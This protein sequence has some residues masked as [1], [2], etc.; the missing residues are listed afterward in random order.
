MS[1]S[2]I[3]LGAVYY[4]E[5]ANGYLEFLELAANL[6]LSWVKLKFEKTLSF[7]STSRQYGRIR[8]TTGSYGIG[9]S[10][11]KSF[12]GLISLHWIQVKG[13]LTG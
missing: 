10:M 9:L 7:R 1:D 2:P 3:L 13:I 4:E 6:E 12:V 5:Y 11:N 8:S